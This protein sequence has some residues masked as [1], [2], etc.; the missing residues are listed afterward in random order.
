VRQAVIDYVGGRGLNVSAMNI[1]VTTVNF[2]GDHGEANVSFTTKNAPG[3]P[4]MSMIYLLEQRGAKWVVTG[5]KQAGG[6][7]HGAGAMPGGAVNPHGG[8]MP[9]G[10]ANPHGAG[11]GGAMPAP[12]DLPPIDKTKK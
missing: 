1:D 2:N 7:P 12:Q 3:V 8:M 4:G 9:G 10:M 11:G 5:R 6:T